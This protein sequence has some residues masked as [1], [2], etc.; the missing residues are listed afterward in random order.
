MG[1][2]FLTA[3]RTN[4]PL[5]P[6]AFV[7]SNINSFD[8]NYTAVYVYDG[9]DTQPGAY[10]ITATT[11]QVGQGFWVLAREN[12]A[13][14]TFDRSMQVANSATTVLKSAKLKKD[15]LPELNLK[16]KYGVYESRTKVIFRDGMTPGLDPM[17][18]VGQ[19]S[20][21]PDVEIYTAL[22]EDNGVNF[23]RQ[24]LPLSGSH[25]SVIPVGVDSEK[26][27][28]V[29]FSADVSPLRNYKFWLEDRMTGIFTDLNANRYS[30]ILPAKTYGTGR[31]FIH[32][33]VV[34][35]VRQKSAEKN[36]L[37]I[38]IWSSQ[39][40]QVNIQGAVSDRAICEVFDSNG[41]KVMETMLSD[42]DYNTFTLP[43]GTRGVC[44]IKVT[45]GEKV[46]T[47]KI[48]LL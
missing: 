41:H 39:E 43:D 31:F 30:V 36:L 10:D 32:V 42:G 2:P 20:T 7:Y 11:V 15:L 48:V 38:R 27:G 1:N 12:G 23:A 24:A 25:K 26:G 37:A 4:V 40:R 3:L 13:T 14:F 44:F 22:V 35:P 46:T 28:P 18:D 33:S 29:V 17:Y 6:T 21:G 9:T 45:D 8:P 34:R 5:E 47:G 19:L 16:A